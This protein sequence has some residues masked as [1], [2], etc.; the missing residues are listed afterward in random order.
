MQHDEF[1]GR[2]VGCGTEVPWTD[3]TDVWG[4]GTHV[5]AL[6]GGVTYG[7]TVATVDRIELVALKVL[8]PDGRARFSRV[9][10]ALDYVLESS[11]TA[12]TGGTRTIVNLS[13]G[14]PRVAELLNEA[15]D[16]VVAAGIPVIV[17][18]GNG[19]VDACTWY[20]DSLRTGNDGNSQKLD[21]QV[22]IIS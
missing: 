17:S 10:E 1:I 5:A 20:D 12:T 6:I 14:T 19:N 3:C 9:I 15:V 18:A 8:G 21:L 7:G 16:R 2:N 22:S 13:L 4:H 11:T